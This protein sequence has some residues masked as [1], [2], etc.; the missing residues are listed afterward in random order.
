[1]GGAVF[2]LFSAAT[3]Y[4]VHEEEAGKRLVCD[5]IFQKAC[6]VISLYITKPPRPNGR[7]NR[8]CI[9]IKI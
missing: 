6:G 5:I 7:P 8:H 2:Y 4:P 3:T 9:A 1:M